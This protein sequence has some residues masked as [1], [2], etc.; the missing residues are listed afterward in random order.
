MKWWKNKQQGLPNLRE[1]FFKLCCVLISSAIVERVF[2]KQGLEV[3]D[4]VFANAQDELVLGQTLASNNPVLGRHKEHGLCTTRLAST[5]DGEISDSEDSDVLYIAV[6]DKDDVNGEPVNGE[7]D[8]GADSDD[9]DDNGVDSDVEDS[10]DDNDD[11]DDGDVENKDDEKKDAIYLSG[12][13]A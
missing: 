5:G 10:K 3:P 2:S 12:D 11:G 1:L 9:E 8:N 7:D 6:E 13:E 4:H